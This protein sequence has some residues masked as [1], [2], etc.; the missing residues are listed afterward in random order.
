MGHTDLQ[1]TGPL[2]TRDG[3]T[4]CQGEQGHP[5]NSPQMGR[6][7]VSRLR[8]EVNVPKGTAAVAQS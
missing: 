6:D 3:L 8:A 1:V 5:P 4:K 2:A 7:Q